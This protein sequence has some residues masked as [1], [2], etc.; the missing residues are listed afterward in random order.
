MASLQTVSHGDSKRLTRAYAASKALLLSP[1]S[2]NKDGLMF[3]SVGR[4]LSKVEEWTPFVT[5][6]DTVML[7]WKETDYANGYCKEKPL[8]RFVLR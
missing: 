7:R 3:S 6:F 1:S 2:L 5:P 8:K 4:S